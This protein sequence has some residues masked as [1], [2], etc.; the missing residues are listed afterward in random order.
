MWPV[1]LVV[2]LACAGDPVA[3]LARRVHADPADEGAWRALAKHAE[4]GEA[5]RAVRDFL[6]ED[7]TSG[8]A[9][10]ALWQL[11]DRVGDVPLAVE[12]AR[13]ALEHLET[14]SLL[15]RAEREEE[16]L[17]QEYLRRGLVFAE[18]QTLERRRA[19]ERRAGHDT[20]KSDERIARIDIEVRQ[21]AHPDPGALRTAIATARERGDATAEHGALVDLA[22][23]CWATEQF[24]EGL[25]LYRRV[26]EIDGPQPR[27]QRA[28]DRNGAARLAFELARTVDGHEREELLREAEDHARFALAEHEEHGVGRLPDRIRDH[29][30]LAHVHGLL[31]EDEEALIHYEQELALV[32]ELRADVA[33]EGDQALRI[34]H[35]AEDHIFQD[36]ALFLAQGGEDRPADLE[37]ALRTS[38][39]GRVGALEELYRL[40]GLPSPSWTDQDLSLA[41]LQRR[42][43]QA[44]AAL[45]VYFVGSHEAAA[46]CLTAQE[47]LFR[48][49]PPPAELDRIASRFARTAFDLSA[50]DTALATE[51]RKAFDAFLGPFAPALEGAQRLVLVGAGRFGRLPFAALP[52]PA[53]P[54][55]SAAPARPLAARFELALAPTLGALTAEGAPV[56][57]GAPLAIGFGGQAV[58][59]PALEAHFALH[60]LG[61]LGRAEGECRSVAKTLQGRAVTGSEATEAAFRR[62]VPEAELIH[63]AGHAVIDDEDGTRSALL[64]SPSAGGD[65]LL[66]LGDLLE[67]RLGARLVIL[68][69]CRT[70]RG[71][72]FSGEGVGGVARCLLAAGAHNLLLTL[73]PVDDA[74]AP[75]FIDHMT[76][77]LAERKRPA[78]ALAEAQRRMLASK[79]TAHPAFW[80][81]F[82][83]Y[84]QDDLLR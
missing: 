49:L 23:H 69:A 74:K 56:A 41:E 61:V 57:S 71:E 43:A 3:E 44:K 14:E 16:N 72:S 31:G 66:T 51:G 28:N 17:R 59:D 62:L 54:S 50:R 79:S 33:I 81:S 36:F 20:K 77:A 15:E 70:A 12:A 47:I 21:R 11:A 19:L 2:L 9:W 45:L 7:P 84:G 39:L 76:R 58:F 8:R 22:Y 25:E 60:G 52:L 63:F 73:A 30:V 40:R 4:P 83:L 75:L 78:T 35:S 38:E 65:G 13:G 26:L 18:R 5:L 37:R 67:L 46:V 48:A 68:S 82:V 32:L 10:H 80:A 34:F 64:L 6:G 24:R 42:V 55:P 27:V 53:E 1:W 29:C